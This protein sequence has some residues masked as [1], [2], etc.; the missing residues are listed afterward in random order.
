MSCRCFIFISAMFSCMHVASIFSR[1]A[2]KWYWRAS[3]KRSWSPWCMAPFCYETG[4]PFVFMYWFWCHFVWFKS[5]WA[6]FGA[7]WDVRLPNGSAKRFWGPKW[8]REAPRSENSDF[9]TPPQKPTSNFSVFVSVC[10]NYL[11]FLACHLQVRFFC[12][13]ENHVQ[14]M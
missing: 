14:N 6:W 7:H 10:L 8:S 1:I 4:L 9:G 3:E 2:L 11:I 13:C 5:V 12:D